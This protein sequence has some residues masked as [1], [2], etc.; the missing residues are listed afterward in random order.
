MADSKIDNPR[1]KEPGDKPEAKKPKFKPQPLGKA[2]P[3]DTVEGEGS[4]GLT[5]GG[6]G[7]A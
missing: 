3:D 5:I 6:G 2:A 7:H 4:P 1:P